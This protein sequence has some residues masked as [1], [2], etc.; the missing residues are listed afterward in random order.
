MCRLHLATLMATRYVRY[1]EGPVG[2]L[3]TLVRD[4][5]SDLGPLDMLETYIKSV[6]EGY[7]VH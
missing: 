6:S 3:G 7:L 1:I 4:M 2:L 5:L